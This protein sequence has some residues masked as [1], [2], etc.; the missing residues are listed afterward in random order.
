MISSGISVTY[1]NLLIS[2]VVPCFK[3]I[4]FTVGNLM[5]RYVISHVVQ[6]LK[7]IIYVCMICWA[8]DKD[9]KTFE[10][11]CVQQDKNCSLSKLKEI[12]TVP[13][14]RNHQETE[15]EKEGMYKTM[16]RGY[17]LEL[18]ENKL[19]HTYNDI[20]TYRHRK[21]MLTAEDTGLFWDSQKKKHENHMCSVH[22]DLL[23]SMFIKE[24]R[25]WN[26]KIC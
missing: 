22:Q 12:N 5:L 1:L 3:I 7:S 21:P 2:R 26:E 8:R 14:G 9:C 13:K 20:K 24:S 25:N 19:L 11:A 17:L 4:I 18:Q 23:Y 6:C 10:K 16:R 15:T